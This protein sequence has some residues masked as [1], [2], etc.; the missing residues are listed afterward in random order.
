MGKEY[1]SAESFK[2]VLHFDQVLVKQLVLWA[3]EIKV[4]FSSLNGTFLPVILSRL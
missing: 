2:Y 3:E 4:L 1:F